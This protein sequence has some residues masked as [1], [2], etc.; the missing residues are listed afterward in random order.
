MK[1]IKAFIHRNRVA[2][3]VHALEAVGLCG[4]DCNLS[5]IDV[6]GTLEALDNRERDY[7]LELGGTVITEVKLELVLPDEQVGQA[8][9]L[10]REHGRTGQPH[11][12]WVFVSSIDESWRID[13]A[14]D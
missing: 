3:V 7:S 11:A 5:V 13:E 4:A 10:I 9:A 12:G 6:K 1:E 14:E 2:D 8:V